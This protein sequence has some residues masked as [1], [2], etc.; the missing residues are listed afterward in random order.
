MSLRWH[1]HHSQLTVICQRASD[2][3]RRKVH[4]FSLISE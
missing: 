2:H 4:G 1:I 3:G